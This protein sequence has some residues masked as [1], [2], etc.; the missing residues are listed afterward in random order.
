LDQEIIGR[1]SMDLQR[2]FAQMRMRTDVGRIKRVARSSSK[3]KANKEEVVMDE[4]MKTLD[5]LKEYYGDS[6]I[7]LKDLDD[8]RGL[9]D[10]TAE[11]LLKRH[12]LNAMT[13]PAKT[14]LWVK[15]LGQFTGF[16]SLLLEGGAALCLVAWLLN[17][18]DPNNLY[19]FLVLGGVVILTAIFTFLQEA[20]TEKTMEGFKKLAPSSAKVRRNGQ[21]KDIDSKFLVVGDIVVVKSGDRVPADIIMIKAAGMKVDNS[22]LTGEADAQERKVGG[23]DN[24]PLETKNISFYSTLCVKG[25]GVGIV[26]F[27]GDQTIMG[28]IA[29]LASTTSA[30]STPLHKEI[31]RF[32]YIISAIALFLGFSFCG[33]GFYLYPTEYIAN[34]IFTI[35]IIVANVPEGL[36]A[37]VTVALTLTATRM[38]IK[39]VL[40]KHLESVETLGSTTTIASD[41]TGTLTQNRM[42]VAH[43]WYDK[44]IFKCNTNKQSAFGY[45][46]DDKTFADL[47]KIGTLCNKATFN[48]GPA[49]EKRHVLDK[50][51]IGDA[52]ESALIKFCQ[53]LRDIVE[54]RAANPIYKANGINYEIPFNSVNKW[55]IS[56]HKEETGNF[57][58]LMKGAP[59]RVWDMSTN[60]QLD[61]KDVEK[62][63]SAIRAFDE[64]YDKLG[65]LGERV[66]GFALK[67]VDQEFIDNID[68]DDLLNTLVPKDLCFVGLYAMVDPP[69]AS[70][71]EAVHK[72]N[73]AG[74][75]VIMVTGDHFKTATAIAR[76][77]GI[78]KGDTIDDIAKREGKKV[79]EIDPDR[80]QAAVIQ[81]KN[82]PFLTDEQWNEVLSKQEVVFARTSPQQKLIIV[83]HCQQRGEIVAVTGDGVNDSPALKKADIGIAMGI[84]GSEVSK[85]AADMILMDDN[86]ASIVN[87]VQEG[88]VIFDNLKK[89]IA[90]TLSSN[91][92]EISPFLIFITLGIPLPLST[93]LI[94]CV[95]LGTDMIPAISLAYEEA[96]SDIMRRKPRNSKTDK[97]VSTKLIAFS[98]F[99]IGIMQAVAGFFTYFCVL[100]YYGFPMG[101]LSGLI[102]KQP[103]TFLQG[104]QNRNADILNIRGELFTDEKQ[105]EI[106]AEA[107]TSYLCTI[108]VV[109]WADILIC[110][111]RRL[112]I[113]QHGMGNQML[114]FGLV[115][116][117]VLGLFIS[118]TP[119]LG[120]AI[121]GSRPL[122]L[123][124]L[125]PGIPFAILIF[126]YDEIRKFIMRHNPGGWVERHTFW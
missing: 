21:T 40:V 49:N 51:T 97:L 125:L 6:G 74:I 11:A 4:H 52:S 76:Q 78:I 96:E 31:N 84:M 53:P 14:P 118:Y 115:S 45:T 36:L 32:I 63:E 55:Q 121:F 70:V 83:E 92:P 77:V 65:G 119:F 93:V 30:E 38:K 19:L 116:E 56:L 1:K 67:Y 98:Y 58:I 72:C 44:K 75:K 117:T 22:A 86:F 12:G 16:F 105:L 25:S 54:Y 114:N 17:I 57:S 20:K 43:L 64:A 123:I 33:I 109:Q 69:R 28:R 122:K 100:G 50:T 9:S 120:P 66:L 8:C 102:T 13:P 18:Q 107:Q 90:Y 27:T 108:I 87:G 23:T 68:P 99:Q 71:P 79:E 24:N 106:L 85:D 35:G 48:P 10:D 59:E 62:D 91:I 3:K 94:L 124:F 60:I 34:L 41:K 104:S 111:T 42:T 81:G 126:T 2:G 110:K 47:Q 46:S 112:S 89:S 80:A 7:N 88:R 29:G 15:F 61:G 82:I 39:N 73:T 5:E 103:T 101:N 113:F 95:D 37:T 26:C